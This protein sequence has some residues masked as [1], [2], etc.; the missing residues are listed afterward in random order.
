M[1]SAYLTHLAYLFD[2]G[3]SVTSRG[4]GTREILNKQF[5]VNMENCVLTLMQRKLSYRFM[6]EEALWILR[7]QNHVFSPKLDRFS[8]D[9]IF[10]YGAYGPRFVAQLPYVTK[11]LRHDAGTR[12]AVLILWRESP[13]PSSKDLPCTLTMQF[14][15]RGDELHTTVNMRSSDA[16]TG[17]P[18]DV[19]SFTMMSEYVRR[20]TYPEHRLGQLC[21]NAGSAHIYEKDFVAAQQLIEGR[22]KLGDV[23][24]NRGTYVDTAVERMLHSGGSQDALVKELAA[25]LGNYMG[26]VFDEAQDAP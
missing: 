26:T 10:M 14:I 23:N 11:E 8:D 2:C 22:N 12:R 17:I 13:D 6:L 16:W 18:Y 15:V 19:F 25:V 4:M 9:T 3:S 5:R 1:N 24:G 21:I 7:G 20:L